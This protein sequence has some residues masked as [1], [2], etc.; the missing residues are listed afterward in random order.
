MHQTVS[1]HRGTGHGS[2]QRTTQSTGGGD[3]GSEKR[4]PQAD[5]RAGLT[6]A[7]FYSN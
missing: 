1:P 6:Q 3:N 5:T 4:L 2:P 7:L